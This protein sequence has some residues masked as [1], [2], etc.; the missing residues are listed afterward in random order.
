MSEESVYC[1][2]LHSKLTQPCTFFWFWKDEIGQSCGATPVTLLQQMEKKEKSYKEHWSSKALSKLHRR[3]TSS[4]HCPPQPLGTDP[5]KLFAAPCTQLACS[6]ERCFI[7][8]TK[9]YPYWQSST[10]FSH[11]SYSGSFWPCPQISGLAGEAEAVV[12]R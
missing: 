4:H 5:W 3:T 12:T 2:T 1:K 6:P 8:S 9:N 10:F 11:S 7:H